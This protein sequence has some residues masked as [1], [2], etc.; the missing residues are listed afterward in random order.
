MPCLVGEAGRSQPDAA[1]DPTKSPD[2]RQLDTVVMSEKWK[3]G[4]QNG[5]WA[6]E[7]GRSVDVRVVRNRLA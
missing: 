2:A 6:G 4:R 7:R 5:S 3:R 1:C